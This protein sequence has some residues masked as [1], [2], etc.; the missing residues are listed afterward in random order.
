MAQPGSSGTA[1]SSLTY[2]NPLGI[3]IGDPGV[4]HVPGH[5]YIYGTGGGTFTSTNLVEWVSVGNTTPISETNCWFNGAFWAPEVYQVKNQFYMFF[6]AQWTNNPTHEQENFRV[7]VAV[8]DSPAGPFK[9]MK[10]G[11]IFDPGYPAIED[12]TDTEVF[13][14]FVQRVLLPTLKPGDVVVMDNLSP[15][16]NS[17]TVRWLE[18]AGMRV[19]F[20]PP[21]SPDFNPIEKLWS[22][23][24][25]A[26]RSAK[27]RTTAA[28]NEAIAAALSSI[29]SEDAAGRFASFGYSII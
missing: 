8:S 14:A 18:Q 17:E 25:A 9:C 23:V 11:P 20:L 13:R 6:S 4:L 16:K 12:A 1:A 10:N 28:L 5:Y 3:S 26:L 15:H 24:K 21:Y 19:R 22:K 27:A 29:T 2:T 7:G